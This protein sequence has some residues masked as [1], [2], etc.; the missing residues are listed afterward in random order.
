MI[1]ISLCMIVK[2]EEDI[3]ERC[4]DS[5]SQ[6]VD[7]IIIVDTGSTDQTKKIAGIYT[8]KIYDFQWIDDF[9]AARNYAFEKA[10]KDYIFWMDADDIILAD[11]IV[12]FKKLK[13]ELTFDTDI[14]M[15]HYNAGFDEQGRTIFSYYRER[16]SK[17]S[18]NFKWQE[19]VHEYLQFGG[20][21][22]HSDVCITHAKKKEMINSRNLKIYENLL[23]KGEKLTPRGTYYYA[24]ELKDNGRLE[25]AAKMFDQFLESGLGWLED[26]I[27]ACSE[28]AK[29]YQL[30]DRP[31]KALE[32]TLRSFYYDT[33]RAELCCQIGYHFKTQDEYRQAA[34]WFEL[35]LKVERPINSWGFYQEDYS[36]YIPSLECAVCYDKLG[37]IEKAEQYNDMA[38]LYKPDSPSVIYNKNYFDSKKK[39]SLISEGAKE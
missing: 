26:N 38:A 23:D 13:E 39:A 12:R 19:P 1:T 22:V 28:L 25:E 16:L 21:I 20:K 36:S 14:I 35:A 29:C 30:T 15:M 33:P 18:R 27:T 2:N 7:E 24:R 9:S 11:D 4:L 6:L 31:Q 32:S 5:V 17:R 3:L 8:D 10:T 37:D 34:F